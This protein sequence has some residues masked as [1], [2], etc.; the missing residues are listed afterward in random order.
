MSIVNRVLISKQHVDLMHFVCYNMLGNFMAC[1][2][3]L[4]NLHA[5]R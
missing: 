5:K 4:V 2:K 3:N 1:L